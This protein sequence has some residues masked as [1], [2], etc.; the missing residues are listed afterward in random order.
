MLR[1]LPAVA[2]LVLGQGAV[3]WV[4]NH[5]PPLPS[6]TLPL[7][8]VDR[9]VPFWTWTVWPYLFVHVMTVLLS[10]SVSDRRVFRRLVIAYAVASLL[11]AAFFIFRPTHYVRPPVPTD[12]SLSSI[13]YRWLVLVDTPECCFPSLHVIP[14][15]LACVAWWQDRGPAG[16]WPSLVV[17]VCSLSIL[18][19]KQHYFW[20]MLG[21]WA[22]AAVGVA[23][24]WAL[25]PGHSATT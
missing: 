13:A 10:L 19:T 7:L 8:P 9:W 17:G 20:D 3:Y 24:A 25:V 21:G 22:V 16:F 5:Y 6:R 11:A 23:V 12:S 15:T 2:L 18:T 14:S 4:L 1:N